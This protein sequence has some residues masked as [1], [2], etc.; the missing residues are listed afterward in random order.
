[1]NTN[2]KKPISAFNYFGGKNAI[3]LQKFILQNL[4]KSPKMHLVDVFG[5]SAAIVLNHKGGGIKMRTFNDLNT[6]IYNFFQQLRDNSEELISKLELSCHCRQ[7]YESMDLSTITDP[8]EKAR[9]FFIRTVS[10]FGNTGSLNK[11][12]SWSYTINDSRYNVSQSVARLLSKIE[13]L[14]LVVEELRHIQIECRD[15]RHILSKY[16]G[17]NTLFYVDPPYVRTTRSG[18]ISYK[19]ELSDQ[20]QRELISILN[21]LKGHYLLSGYENEIYETHLKYKGKQTSHHHKTNALKRTTEV[22]WSNYELTED[23]A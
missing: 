14:H 10:S 2:T 20:D 22:V 4:H 8:V 18:H 1:M 19:H 5:G 7:D 23:I 17:E 13:G 16:D 3:K 9:A 11:N 12:N 15:F 21:E 6:D